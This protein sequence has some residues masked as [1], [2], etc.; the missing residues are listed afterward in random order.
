MGAEV[1]VHHTAH[2]PRTTALLALPALLLVACGGEGLSQ[3]EAH[4]TFD[5][6][7]LVSDE[8]ITSAVGSVEGSSAAFTVDAALPDDLQLEGVLDGD[9][10]VSGEHEGAAEL[11]YDLSLAV[12]PL[13]V[14][15]TASGDISGHDVSG[16][17]FGLS[18]PL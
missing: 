9:L 18:I 16:W 12:S 5:T 15:F 3:R 10:V 4:D 8:L 7:N 14:S 17:P 1:P 13:D 6:V 11:D 2:D